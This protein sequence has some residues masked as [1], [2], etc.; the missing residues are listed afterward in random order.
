ML[1]LGANTI[2]PITVAQPDTYYTDVAIAQ[3]YTNEGQF[4]DDSFNIA[5]PTIGT[6]HIRSIYDR[7]GT[8]NPMGS[9]ATSLAQLMDPTLSTGDPANNPGLIERPAMFLRI[10]KGTYLPDDDV[11][12]YDNAAYGLG[13]SGQL[14]RQIIGYA[15][16]EPDGSVR[17]NVP[18]DVPLSFSILDRNGRRV[19]GTPRHNNW[20]TVRP[21]EEVTCHGCHDHISLWDGSGLSL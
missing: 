6:I 8:F 16:I 4:I 18:S 9:T 2:L 19:A 15:P 13:G 20:I 10:V 5:D 7:D 1:E 14:M 11:R 17:V 12:D 3:G 21:G